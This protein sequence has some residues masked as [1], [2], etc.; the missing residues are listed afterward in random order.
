M[1]EMWATTKR[2]FPSGARGVSGVM[3]GYRWMQKGG[4]NN[5]SGEET[6]L[7]ES[8][9]DLVN[10]NWTKWMKAWRGSGVEKAMLV[11]PSARVV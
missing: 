11:F 10:E 6:R 4:G 5:N 7:R 3:D 8:D 2:P 1:N 9:I